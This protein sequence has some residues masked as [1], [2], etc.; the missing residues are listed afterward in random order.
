MFEASVRI[1]ILA[2]DPPQLVSSL[3]GLVPGLYTAV[4]SSKGKGKATDPADELGANLATL[5]LNDSSK[6]AHGISGPRVEGD[7]R[8][9]F[10]SILLLYHL[11][12]GD[13]YRTFFSTLMS[14]TNPTAA[15]L[16][17]PFDDLHQASDIP[18]QPRAPTTSPDAP[19]AFCKRRDLWYALRA[20]RALAEETFNPLL[21]FALVSDPKA[22]VYE[23]AVLSWAAERVQ[24]RAWGIMR[25]AYLEC[26]LDWVG[27]WVGEDENEAGSWVEAEGGR[28][29][30]G[31]VPVR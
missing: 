10:A 8:I 26:R 31:K 22:S 17:R 16:R 20:S 18:D 3:S 24:K 9:G 13:S 21:Y 14:I 5:Q 6:S 1:S 30:D 29:I 4:D 11:A 28:V 2:R 23:R 27:R 19:I 25:K 15:K 7:R 12:H